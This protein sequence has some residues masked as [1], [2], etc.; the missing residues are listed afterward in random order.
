MRMPIC[1]SFFM[2]RTVIRCKAQ[3]NQAK[4]YK[5][6]HFLRLKGLRGGLDGAKRCQTMAKKDRK[7]ETF[8]IRVTEAF[9]R[10]IVRAAR[11]VKRAPSDWARVAIE[12]EVEKSEKQHGEPASVG[13]QKSAKGEDD[14]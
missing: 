11:H 4:F 10:R 7:T 14:A 8:G 2:L 1:V 12:D 13:H 5:V 6:A 9:Y 3:Q